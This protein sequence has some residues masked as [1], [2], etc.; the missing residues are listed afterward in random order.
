MTTFPPLPLRAPL[1]QHHHFCL[2][3][4][5]PFLK[6][7]ISSIHQEHKPIHHNASPNVYAQSVLN[8]DNRANVR[9]PRQKNRLTLSPGEHKSH[10][11]IF[12]QGREPLY[13]QPISVLSTLCTPR[14]GSRRT[15]NHLSLSRPQPYMYVGT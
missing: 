12:S 10:L 6:Q 9:P 11:F 13:I 7:Q 2:V 1:P 3:H 4:F 5:H 14:A 8:S 15:S